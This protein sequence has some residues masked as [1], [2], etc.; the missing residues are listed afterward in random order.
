MKVE[1]RFHNLLLTLPLPASRRAKMD[2]LAVCRGP[3][4][5]P[6]LL[7][8]LG[9]IILGS[10]LL[11]FITLLRRIA[12]KPAR[13]HTATILV[14]GDIGRSPRMMYHADSLA[15]HGWDTLVVGYGDSLPMPAL[16]ESPRVQLLHLANPSTPLLSLP[17]ILRAPIRIAYQI[18]SVL[19]LCLW[20]RPYHSEILLVQNPPSIPTLALAQLVSYISGAK[21]IIDWHNTGYSILAMRVG[22]KSPLVRVAEW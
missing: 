13:H 1:V 9:V 21:L 6:L 20:R 3:T 15:Q 8:V 14:L 16:L 18:V 11:L 19:Y 22:P 4:W 5:H 17:W 7:S 12:S 2:F 10:L